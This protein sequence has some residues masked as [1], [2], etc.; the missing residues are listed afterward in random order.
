MGTTIIKM[1]L[2]VKFLVSDVI[3][4][5]VLK[6]YVFALL[7]LMFFI[8]GYIRENVTIVGCVMVLTSHFCFY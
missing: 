7:L 2:Y 1:L 4:I 5:L 3:M 6:S 8:G